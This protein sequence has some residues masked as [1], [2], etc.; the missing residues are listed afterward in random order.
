MKDSAP[1]LK[2]Q[3]FVNNEHKKEYKIKESIRQANNSWYN[4]KFH[5]NWNKSEWVDPKTRDR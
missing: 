4:Q 2:R 1:P 5:L 3:R